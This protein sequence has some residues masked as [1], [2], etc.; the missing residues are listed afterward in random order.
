MP[1]GLVELNGEWLYEEFMG[2]AAV[3]TLDIDSPRVQDGA[4]PVTN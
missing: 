4:E 1:Q 2:D 3:H